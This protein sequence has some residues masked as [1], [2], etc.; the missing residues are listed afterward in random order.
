MNQNMILN[1]IGSLLIYDFMHKGVISSFIFNC[2]RFFLGE[3]FFFLLEKTTD[4]LDTQKINPRFSKTLELVNPR[5]S[6]VLVLVNPRFSKVLGLVNP[7]FS[8]P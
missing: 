4:K 2:I 6:K 5:F 8:K 1:I 7:K 3:R